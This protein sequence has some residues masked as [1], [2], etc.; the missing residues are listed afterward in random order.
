[1]KKCEKCG[2][3]FPFSVKI[4][5]ILRN[6]GNRRYCLKCSPF[7]L[8]NTKKIEENGNFDQN[9]TER[10]CPMCKKNL[11]ITEFYNRRNK[12]GSSVYCKICTNEQT[13]LRQRE[14]KRKCIN[15]KGGKCEICGYN[16]SQNSLDFHHKNREEKKFG[17]AHRK[18]NSFN[19]EIKMELDKCSLICRNC[20]GELHESEGGWEKRERE[21]GIPNSLS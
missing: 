14:F 16:K 7:G 11:P 2:G 4:D 19:E 17:L 12:D 9:K 15:Y 10:T 13:I 6:L 1:M 3:E 8:H 18:H 5:G 20:H 21:L